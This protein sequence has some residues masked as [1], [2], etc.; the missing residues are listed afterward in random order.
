M[1][2]FICGLVTHIGLLWLQQHSAK[3]NKFIPSVTSHVTFSYIHYYCTWKNSRSPILWTWK[4][5]SWVH[6]QKADKRTVKEFIISFKQKLPQEI[7]TFVNSMYSHVNFY[8]NA[9]SERFLKISV[10]ISTQTSTNVEY[11]FS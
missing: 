5:Y 1:R 2:C 9:A 3:C 8:V 11:C 7:A 10:K 6:H 4:L